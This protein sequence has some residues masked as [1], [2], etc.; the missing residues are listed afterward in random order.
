MPP[1]SRGFMKQL[2]GLFSGFLILCTNLFLFCEEAG[3]IFNIQF[4]S[5]P[6]VIDGHVNKEE[7]YLSEP[8]DDFIQIIPNSGNQPSVKTVAY[9]LYDEK[10]L[11]FAFVCYYPEPGKIVKD[12]T[13][14]DRYIGCDDYIQI[15]LDTYYDRRNCYAFQINPIGT[16]QDVKIIDNGEGGINASWD[17][18]WESISRI[19]NDGWET[20]IKIPFSSL[21]FKNSSPWGINI[22]RGIP[23]RRELISWCKSDEDKILD[24]SKFGKLVGFNKIS[25]KNIYFAIPYGS[26]SWN[27]DWEDEMNGGADIAFKP[28]PSIKINATF[29]PDFAQIESDVDQID[30]SKLGIWLSEKR[31]FFL[32]GND[33][34]FTPLPIMYTRSISEIAGGIKVIGN[35]RGFEFNAF[36]VRPQWEI[37]DDCVSFRIKKGILK[38][39]M[40]GL[41][42]ISNFSDSLNSILG[43]D[44]YVSFP[45]QISLISQIACSRI[46]LDKNILDRAIYVNLFRQPDIKGIYFN[47]L[48]KDIGTSFVCKNGYIPLID[49]KENNVG[50]G[51]KFFVNKAILRDFSIAVDYGRWKNHQNVLI[52]EGIYPHVNFDFQNRFSLS[53][54]YER[55][56]RLFNNTYYSNSI[57][58]VSFGYEI[59]GQKSIFINYSLGDFYNGYMRYPQIEIWFNPFSKIL[60]QIHFDYQY[61]DYVSYVERTKIIATK[62]NYRIS[63]QLSLRA[64]LQWSDVSKSLDA[65]FLIQYEFFTGSHIYFVWNETRD[66]TD[67]EYSERLVLPL[68][69]RSTLFKI[70]Y[71]FR[72]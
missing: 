67:F 22:H 18:V 61:L 39:S 11:Y 25:E 40:V 48:Y 71:E 9:G 62:I 49:L 33:V 27:I 28:I 47:I 6:P 26:I 29:N 38:S 57:T 10:N 19:T 56:K 68:R 32:D 43:F 8:V 4:T 16:Q 53:L 13:T 23:D 58:S 63:N 52:N 64:F 60:T 35:I 14:R 54:S 44:T 24:V 45:Q 2:I 50:L 36:H 55:Y 15:S 3:R 21:Q 1:I 17:G 20:E 34:L 51:Y 66:I 41:S 69:E 42:F 65:N 30:L 46:K 5:V 12:A 31:P 59:G 7:W 37:S 70:S 72:F